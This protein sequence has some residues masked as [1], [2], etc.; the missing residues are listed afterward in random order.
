MKLFSYLFKTLALW[1]TYVYG[2]MKIFMYKIL[3]FFILQCHANEAESQDRPQN[4][5]RKRTKEKEKN[6]KWAFE[7]WKTG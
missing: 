4:H 5:I 1:Y 2:W 3:S 7:A 6:W